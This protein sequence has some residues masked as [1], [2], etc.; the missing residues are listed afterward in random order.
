MNRGERIVTLDVLRGM[1]LFGMILVHFHQLMEVPS[2]GVEDLVGW[3]IWM[4]VETKSWATFAFLFGAGF[5]ILMRRAE[6][7]GLKLVPLFFR[8]MLALALFGVAV[9]VLFGLNILIEYAF[10]GVALLLVRNWPTRALL[11]LALISAIALSVYSTVSPYRRSPNHAAL[12]KAE[13]QGTY[14][15]AMK[16]RAEAMTWR[17]RQP[18]ALIPGS[19]FVLFILGL[20]SIRHGVFADPKATRRTIVTAMIFGLVS[21]TLAWFVLPKLPFSNGFGIIN[22]QWLA[23]TYIGG[24]TLLLAYRPVWKERLRAFATTGRMALTNYVLQAAIISWL[25]SGYGLGL[26]IRPYYELPATILLF[27]ILVLL[28]TFWLARFSHGPLERIWRSFTLWQVRAE[29]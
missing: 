27:L 10:W 6:A 11:L 1:A 22:D 16:E 24:I 18:R 23:F 15:E 8:R 20:L 5:A 13:A 12:E 28:S 17:W 7:R 9:E 29:A 4:G 25:A 26:K 21:W 19:T 2:K 3:V 14:G